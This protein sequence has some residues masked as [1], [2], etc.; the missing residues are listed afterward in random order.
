M[1]ILIK[2]RSYEISELIGLEIRSSENQVLGWSRILCI[3]VKFPNL[4]KSYK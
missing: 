4:Y 1:S 3:F 2:I